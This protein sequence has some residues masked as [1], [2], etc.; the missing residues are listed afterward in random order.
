LPL[1][2]AP[3]TPYDEHFPLFRCS[4]LPIIR[5]IISLRYF[6]AA[7]YYFHSRRAIA[8]FTSHFHFRFHEPVFRSLPLYDAAICRSSPMLPRQAF[9]PL[10]SGVIDARCRATPDASLRQSGECRAHA[11]RTLRVATPAAPLRVIVA[12][13]ADALR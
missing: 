6:C 13:A 12:T 11:M 7:Y 5:V 10:F 9:S 4:F 8:V 3:P 2:S 1:P